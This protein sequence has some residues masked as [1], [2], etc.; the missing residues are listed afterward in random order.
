MAHAALTLTP[1]VNQTRTPALNQAAISSCDMIRFIPDQQLGGLPQKLGGWIKKFPQAMGSMV[2]ALWA[3]ADIN[4][5]YYLAV[6]C[7]ASLQVITYG[8]GGL[9]VPARQDITPHRDEHNVPVVV[10]TTAGSPVV[11]ITDPASGVTNYD[12]VFI[13][14]HIAV[15]GLVLYGLYQCT[16][17]SANTYTIVAHDRLGNPMPATASVVGGGV[18]ANYSTVIGVSFVT[19]TLPVHGYVVGDTYTAFVPITVGGIQIYGDYLVQS[20]PT[21]GTFTIQTSNAAT[22]TLG[23]VPENGGNA[24][25]IYLIGSGPLPAGSGFG[26][27]GFG[28]GGFG[29]GTTPVANPGFPIVTNDWSLDN[30]GSFLVACPVG[31]AIYIWN[32]LSNQFSASAVSQ[33]PPFNTGVFVA[34]PQ[35]Q[36]VAYGSTFTGIIDPLLVRWCDVNNFTSWIALVQNQAGSY[37]LTRGSKIVGAIQGPQQG[38]LWTDV[39]LWDMQYVGQPNIYSFNEVGIG[40]GLIGRRAAGTLSGSV[41]WMSQSQFY[42]LSGD[43][44]QVIYCPIWDVIFQNLDQTQLDKIRFAGN[45]RFGEA[46]WYFPTLTSGGEIGMYVKYNI[47]LQQWDYGTL[48]RTAWVNQSVLGPPI[49]AGVDQFLYQHEIGNDDDVKPMVAYFQTGYFAVNEG[50]LKSFMDQV[51][52]DMK[53][54]L[55]EGAQ[56][57]NVT[58]TFYTVDYPGET[59]IIYGPFTVTQATKFITPRFRARLVSIRIGSSDI[60]SF[61]RLGQ[62]RYR[63]QID[64]KYY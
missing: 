32:P 12:S 41:Y 43:G 31:G 55:F 25:Y 37:R 29:S 56:N 49:G 20:T 18:V 24:R 21:A 9:G 47:I 59:P 39:G 60:G 13:A 17:V 6:G 10:D 3:W 30:W 48:K 11:L 63:T 42:V 28:T 8:D 45:S 35:R 62:M 22:A 7:E 2:R 33:A 44:V 52:P 1:G 58:I 50:D 51:W 38:L 5:V 14:T 16:Q 64:G 27:G 53:W 36:I 19:V 34:M 61:W 57:A 15:G 40:C 23:P 4:N 26:V 54:G 46:T